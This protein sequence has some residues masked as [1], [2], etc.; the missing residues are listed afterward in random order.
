M[1]FGPSPH[2]AGV[3]VSEGGMMHTQSAAVATAHPPVLSGVIEPEKSRSTVGRW[4]RFGL[5]T[6]TF[7]L[8]EVWQLS[9]LIRARLDAIDAKAPERNKAWVESRIRYPLRALLI[10]ANRDATN[11]VGFSLIVVAGGFATSGIAVAAGAGKGSAGSWVVFGIG[12]VVALAG[13][14]SQ[15][16]RFGVRSNERRTLAVALRQEGWHFANG[17]GEYANQTQASFDQFET[18]VD[19]IHRRI[20]Q[21]DLLEATVHDEADKPKGKAQAKQHSADE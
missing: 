13:A 19:D 20:A 16:L 15:Q 14:L 10:V 4:V 6:P 17:T 9:E 12:L 7:E 1:T 21:V 2:Y 5:G 3:I 8:V 18:R 11:H